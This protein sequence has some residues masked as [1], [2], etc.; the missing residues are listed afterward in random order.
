MIPVVSER[1]TRSKD[2]HRLYYYTGQSP[3]ILIFETLFKINQ[4]QLFK[5]V[6]LDDDIFIVSKAPKFAALK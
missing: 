3:D 2:D 4:Y 5:K 1:I 6:P